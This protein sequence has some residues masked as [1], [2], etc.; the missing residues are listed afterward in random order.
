VSPLGQS[1][2]DRALI[3]RLRAG[4]A[5]EFRTLVGR[6]QGAMVQV[7]LR[8]VS[9]RA[10][11]EEMAQETWLAVITGVGGFE[12]RS[13]LKTWIFSILAN[14]ARTRGARDQRSV[15][16]SS[17][18]DDAA[19]PV[20]GHAVSAERF[21]EAGH[22]LGGHWAS[23]PRRLSEL[24][25]ERLDSD[26]TR[27]AID[28]AIADLPANQERVIRLRDVEGWTADEVCAVLELTDANQRVL[29]HRA[30]AKVRAALERQLE[31]A[32]SFS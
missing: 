24:P 7:A 14:Q 29:L 5:R 19:D 22:R 1:D 8:Y 21:F 10:V 3:E 28:A 31:A 6:Y 17:I 20:V 25:E 27:A 9:S 23:P 18:V 26:E 15:P 13:S 30:R 4:D 12:G 2:A 32:N 16:W 11:A